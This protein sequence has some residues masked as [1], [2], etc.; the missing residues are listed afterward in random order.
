LPA[1]LESSVPGSKLNFASTQ[2]P[3]VTEMAA[4][5]AALTIC[6]QVTLSIPPKRM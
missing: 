5:I 4:R 2:T 6:S 1:A 3:M